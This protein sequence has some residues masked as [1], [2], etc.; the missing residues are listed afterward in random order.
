MTEKDVLK[1]RKI[2]I[3]IANDLYGIKYITFFITLLC[4]TFQLGV[5]YRCCSMILCYRYLFLHLTSSVNEN[6]NI[7][8]LIPIFCYIF[9]QKT[10]IC[11]IFPL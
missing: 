11:P 1:A 7:Y 2:L 5:L 10:L 3:K 6:N 8:N 4:V 9:I